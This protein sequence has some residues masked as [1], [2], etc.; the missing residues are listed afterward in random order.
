LIFFELLHFE[1]D[2]ALSIWETQGALEFP[3]EKY[4][5]REDWMDCTFILAEELEK[6]RRYYEAFVLLLHLIKEE[7]RRPYFKHF[8]EEVETF[9]KELVRLHLR[10]A[11]DTETYVD[12]IQMLLGLG[13]TSRDEARW[14]R[15]LAE[16]LI[17]LGE[18]NNAARIFREALNRDPGL[19]NVIQLR[20]KLNVH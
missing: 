8:M 5:E 11:V 10:S 20:K 18:T 14:M 4:L 2:N 1:E 9:L 17:H 12:C 3:L 6:R 19:P 15:S 7:R 16:A 13:F